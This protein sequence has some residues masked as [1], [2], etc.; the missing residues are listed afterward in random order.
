M[1]LAPKPPVG[2]GIR[3]LDLAIAIC[4]TLLL[5]ASMFVFASYMNSSSRAEL[6]DGAPYHAATFRVISVQYT[7]KIV[8]SDIVDSTGPTASAVGIVEGQRE[9]M[10]LLPYIVPRDQ[11]DLMERFPKGT[12]IPVYLFPTLRGQNRIQRIG[13][14]AAERYQQQV[15]WTT[16][17]ALPVAAGMGML[18]ALLGLGRFFLSRNRMAAATE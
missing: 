16:N 18:T 5:F 8:G 13:T 14:P 6:Y 11:Y 2:I 10:D 4:G 9:A 3:V 17:R 15:T 1:S 7:P 12:V